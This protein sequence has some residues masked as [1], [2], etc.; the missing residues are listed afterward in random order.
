LY[1]KAITKMAAGLKESKEVA[2]IMS[3][4]KTKHLKI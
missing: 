4:S 1:W 2:G 3:L